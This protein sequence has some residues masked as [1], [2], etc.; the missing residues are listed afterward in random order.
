[1][2]RHKFCPLGVLIKQFVRPDLIQ[3]RFRI[4]SRI[5][6]LINA[7]KVGECAG[8]IVRNTVHPDGFICEGIHQL[9]KPFEITRRWS[10]KINRQVNIGHTALYHPLVFRSVV[11]LVVDRKVHHSLHPQ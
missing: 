6:S 5:T 8:S 2:P 4:L 9:I 7:I 11:F 1:M 10:I 3:K